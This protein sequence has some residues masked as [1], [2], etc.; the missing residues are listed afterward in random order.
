[1]TNEQIETYINQIKDTI[2]EAQKELAEVKTITEND[3]TEYSFLLKQLKELEGE[4]ES[5]LTNATPEQ[6]AELLVARE[7]L[8]YTEELM[9]RGI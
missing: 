7:F 5:Y 8:H 9:I 3:P 2:D 4:M 6:K 1:M